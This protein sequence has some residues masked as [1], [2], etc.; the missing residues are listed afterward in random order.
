MLGCRICMCRYPGCDEWPRAC[1][2]A[3]GCHCVCLVIATLD[4][5]SVQ[6][7]RSWCG[8]CAGVKERLEANQQRFRSQLKSQRARHI[9][10][11]FESGGA[12]MPTLPITTWHA[13]SLKDRCFNHALCS[14][15]ARSKVLLRFRCS[16]MLLKCPAVTRRHRRRCRRGRPR[17]HH[18]QRLLLFDGR[19]GSKR[20][21]RR[22]GRQRQRGPRRRCRQRAGSRR[23][24]LISR[25]RRRG[26]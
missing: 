23:W 24:P 10:E 17:T 21:P 20:C 19:R 14:M 16:L 25:G 3:R 15:R 5:H 4:K 22:A 18:H 12:A 6:R 7:W 26:R 2:A 13:R 9:E 11:Y 1:T 8:S